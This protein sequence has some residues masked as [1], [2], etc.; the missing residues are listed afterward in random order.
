M[1]KN[2]KGRNVRYED[3][4]T[5]IEVLVVIAVISVLAALVA[6]NVFGHLGTA[7]DAAARSQIEMLSAALDAYRM[8]NGK[9]P[10]SDQGLG[11]L[12][13]APSNGIRPSNW[14]GPYLRKGVPSDPWQN[15]YIY[16]A[17]GEQSRSGFD[18]LSYGSD[19][20]PG[21]TG[22]AADITSW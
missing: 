18:L 14:R 10:T 22:D 12:V 16:R 5:L 19:G 1:M 4:F 21:G 7:K 8:D 11:A 3:G 2:F 6:P 20:K 17:P 13:E 15:P 9:Y